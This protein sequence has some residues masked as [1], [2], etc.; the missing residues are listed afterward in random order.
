MIRLFLL[1]LLIAIFIMSRRYNLVQDEPTSTEIRMRKLLPNILQYKETD[2]LNADSR[3]KYFTS[4]YPTRFTELYK[5]YNYYP[6]N[7]YNYFPEH[8]YNYN[9]H[10]NIPN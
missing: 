9:S 3:Y 6:Y 1:V 2:L 7:I 8:P 5:Y 10:I 4:H